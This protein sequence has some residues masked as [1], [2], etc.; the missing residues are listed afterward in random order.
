VGTEEVHGGLV[1]YNAFKAF[2][3]MLRQ[4]LAARGLDQAWPCFIV[5]KV[6]TDLHTTDFDPETAQRLYHTV[7]PYGSLI[8]GHYTDWVS[9]P[10][11]YP[12]SGMGGANVGPEFTSEEYLALADL[13]VIED[14]LFQD[15]EAAGRSNF[16]TVLEAAV[17][18]SGRWQ[19][20]LQPD[21]YPHEAGEIG[22]DD[23]QDVWYG[24]T[25]E[26]RSWLTQTG[27]RYIWTAPT[28]LAARDTL[29]QNVSPVISDPHQTVV[30]RI[31]RSM[32]KYVVAFNLFDALVTLLTDEKNV[33]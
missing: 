11:D 15:G 22:S 1:D 7:S 20:W 23:T 17:Y 29:Y 10:H 24:L 33:L 5:G 9:N 4:G 21:E 19:K 8:K 27:A 26:R 12:A 6:G 2:V 3:E 31:A 18:D 13:C 30:D 25:P 32:Q 14:E 16:L 28:V